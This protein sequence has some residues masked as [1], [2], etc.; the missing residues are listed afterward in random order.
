MSTD[1]AAPAETI[2]L[3]VCDDDRGYRKMVARHFEQAGGYV[4]RSVSS[5]EEL[6]VLLREWHADVVLY[7]LYY[8][9]VPRLDGAREVR[10][11]SPQTKVVTLTYSAYDG[12]VR[13]ALETDMNGAFDGYLTKD[14][15]PEDMEVA[16]REVLRGRRYVD[17]IVGEALLTNP[18]LDLSA[19]E[20]TV[21]Q[22]LADG[23]SPK[24]IALDLPPSAKTGTPVG[25]RQVRRLE[26]TARTKLCAKTTHEAV[27][28]ALRRRIVR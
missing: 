6:L 14:V 25:A 26:E 22:G 23:K 13:Q 19:S 5:P 3:V 8:A 21:L 4:V 15:E 11:I 12:D 2:N 7:D 27:S 17:P 16:V 20:R 10:K 9:Q 18:R 24:E 1:T 28:I